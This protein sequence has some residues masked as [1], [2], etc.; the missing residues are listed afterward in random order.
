MLS[1]EHA[2]FETGLMD[3]GWSDACWISEPTQAEGAAMFRKVIMLDARKSI[4]SARLYSTAL[5][6]YNAY[7]NGARVGI[8]D[9]R[10]D[11]Q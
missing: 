9:D 7:V 8:V 11:V 6:I 10:G 5:G 4:R 3:A 2:Y 1:R